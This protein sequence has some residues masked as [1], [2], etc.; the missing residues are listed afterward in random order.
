MG[1]V[2]MLMSPGVTLPSKLRASRTRRSSADARSPKLI[3]PSGACPP[4]QESNGF[5]PRSSTTNASSSA[6][7]PGSRLLKPMPFCW[8]GADARSA[9]G[10]GIVCTP[11]SMF[12]RPPVPAVVLYC[13]GSSR[14]RL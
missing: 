7:P 1:A 11:L 9:I 6:A 12:G 4:S 13:A 8:L 14:S 5:A 2:L 10:G 3:A